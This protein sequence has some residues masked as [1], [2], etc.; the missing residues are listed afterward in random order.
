LLDT[1]PV[2]Q[3][4]KNIVPVLIANLGDEAAWRYIK[5]FTA[6]I[7][8]LHTRRTYARTC[9]RFLFS[10]PIAHYRSNRAVAPLLPLNIV[11][12]QDNVEPRR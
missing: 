11:F 5:F 12:G 7:R 9:N 6:N 2:D 4:A 3:R 10:Q 8:N 1:S